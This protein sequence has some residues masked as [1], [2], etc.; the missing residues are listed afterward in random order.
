MQDNWRITLSF[1]FLPPFYTW[2]EYGV[3]PTLKI[4]YPVS[5]KSQPPSVPQ[6]VIQ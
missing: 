6:K 5:S 2:P 1:H 4:A 3:D